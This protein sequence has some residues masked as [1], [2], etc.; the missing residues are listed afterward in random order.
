MANW[1]LNSI[2]KMIQ[3]YY[4]AMNFDNIIKVW[5]QHLENITLVSKC[6]QFVQVEYNKSGKEGQ[7]AKLIN[8]IDSSQKKDRNKNCN[9]SSPPKQQNEK[10]AVAEF[11][12]INNICS[13]APDMH[14]ALVE[15]VN[16]MIKLVK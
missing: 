1:V 11:L 5:M 2:I 15:L 16:A 10:A 3:K 8:H 4:C 9:K 6:M 14:Y 12:L 7:E 13:K